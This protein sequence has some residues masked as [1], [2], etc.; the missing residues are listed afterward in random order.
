[1]YGGGGDDG[2]GGGGEELQNLEKDLEKGEEGGGG[3]GGVWEAALLSEPHSQVW[4]ASAS[5]PPRT[6]TR[7]PCTARSQ[8]PPPPTG[9]GCITLIPEIQVLLRQLMWVKAIQQLF[10]DGS[11]QQRLCSGGREVT[12][13]PVQHEVKVE[14]RAR[15]FWSE[16]EPEIS[17]QKR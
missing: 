16:P 5:A 6:G 3:L 12:H 11:S 17:Q 10:S 2:G 9:P 15:P 14:V 4:P 13:F 8:P 7:C 1:M